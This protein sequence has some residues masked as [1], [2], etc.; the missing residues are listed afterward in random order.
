MSDDEH[1]SEGEGAPMEIPEPVVVKY[2]PVCTM[3]YEY[4][5]F[6]NTKKQC[7]TRLKEDD[8]DLFAELLGDLNLDEVQDK[9]KPAQV[10]FTEDTKKSAIVVTRIQR[11]KKKFA[12]N[13]AGLKAFGI[14][15]KK[16]S[17]AISGRFAASSSVVGDDEVQVTGD[18]TVDIVDFLTS[19]FDG[20]KKEDIKIVFKN[21]KPKADTS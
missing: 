16:A 8:P 18:V 2:C 6:S 5:E 20:I 1:Q 13:I 3:P 11:T 14:D 19:K 4:C 17:K 10:K 15:L 7:Y 21:K 12:S 9:K